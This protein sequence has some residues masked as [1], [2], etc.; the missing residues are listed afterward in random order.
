M[1]CLRQQQRIDRRLN[2]ASKVLPALYFLY[3]LIR[4]GVG[5]FTRRRLQN[6]VTVISAATCQ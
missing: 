3:G 5:L 2:G 4:G 1:I 6:I